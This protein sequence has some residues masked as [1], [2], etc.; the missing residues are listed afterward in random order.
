VVRGGRAG[1]GGGGFTQNEKPILSPTCVNYEAKSACLVQ[2]VIMF[3]GSAMFA[4]AVFFET[5]CF[6]N[7][8]FLQKG[9]HA[10]PHTQLE[11]PLSAI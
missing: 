9:Y 5:V 8:V 2:I 1:G 6:T 7:S 4:V 3:F 10:T 11:N